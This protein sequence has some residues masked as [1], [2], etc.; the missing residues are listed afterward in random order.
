M[1]PGQA[2]KVG[3][4]AAPGAWR[5]AVLSPLL[6]PCAAADSSLEACP[7]RNYDPILKTG[8]F[9]NFVSQKIN[10]EGKRGTKLR[11]E[12]PLLRFQFC[13]KCCSLL[14]A[15]KNPRSTLRLDHRTFKSTSFA[16]AKNVKRTSLDS[17]VQTRLRELH[18]IDRTPPDWWSL[19]AIH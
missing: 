17:H 4:T 9:L 5:C 13:K 16:M 2:S 1:R 7:G 15:G 14:D 19:R 10:V 11:I 3:T 18:F 6:S 12:K 8:I